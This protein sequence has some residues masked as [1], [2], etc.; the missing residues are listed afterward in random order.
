MPVAPTSVIRGGRLLDAA[1]HRA[2]PADLLIAGDT[3]AEVGPPG[4][5]APP[6]ASVVDAAGRMLIPGLINA[7]THGHGSLVKGM[8]DRWSLELLLNAG[9]WM[10]AG[11]SLEDLRTAAALN[12]VELVRKG[13]TAAY[14]L[15]IEL[16][17]PT[18]EGLEAV[19]LGYADVGVRAVVAPMMA[20]RL[21]Y[22]A[23]PGLLEAFPPALRAEA[24]R[25]RAAP[26]AESLAALARLLREGRSAR[27][28][29]DLALA[30]TIP[31]HCTDAFM[32]AC[33]DLARE[34]DARLHMHLAESKAQALAGPRT[35]GRSLTA[36]LDA[37]GLLG[38]HFTAAHAIWL[39][40]D[41][42][43][44]LA[45]HGATIAHNP[46]SNLRLGSG[47][48]RARAMLA[49]GITVGIGTDG[50]QCSDHQNLFETARIASGVSRIEGPDVSRWLCAE[51]VFHMLTAGGAATLG[52][53]ARLGR[54][55]PGYQ[56]DVVFLDL[57]H[58]NYVP[59][60][61]PL[62]Q[63]LYCEDGSAVDS[64][65]I[66]GRM[67]LER[68]R[69]AALDET[70]LFARA[71]AATERLRAANPERRALATRLEPYVSQYCIGLAQEPA[72]VDRWIGG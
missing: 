34:T 16:P 31:L 57:G 48:A 22:Q 24:E 59:L 5:P 19:R 9:S 65:M 71:Q 28:R 8:G 40:D 67:V 18:M 52:L 42:L 72:A 20:D 51:E 35:Y 21:L 7:H 61:D 69:L 2:D 63:V 36:H 38:P 11:R 23:L 50:S 58:I 49:A 68:R 13:C 17:V 43:R 10:N 12:A 62:L 25:L 54:L 41:D 32:A 14:D 45:D 30:P 44:R 33:R 56:A 3:I 27:D 66:G 4:L 39:D 53:D 29:F 64:V 15:F 6:D 47:V 60:N 37:L 1:T 26:F 46:G 70:A 55:A